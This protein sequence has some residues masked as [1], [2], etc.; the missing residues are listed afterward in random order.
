MR[1][2][3]V[4]LLYP[5]YLD[6]TWQVILVTLARKPWVFDSCRYGPSGLVVGLLKTGRVICGCLAG[7]T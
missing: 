5:L 1:Y 3:Q 7:L 4:T 6:S 2:T